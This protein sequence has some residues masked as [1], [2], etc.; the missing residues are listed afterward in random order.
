MRFPNG[1]PSGNRVPEYSLRAGRRFRLRPLALD[2]DLRPLLQGVGR[3]I[4]V[5][6]VS[7]DA[8]NKEPGKAGTHADKQKRVAGVSERQT[9]PDPM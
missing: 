9:P 4:H 6:Q 5:E 7:H 2:I 8:D 3:L 1:V